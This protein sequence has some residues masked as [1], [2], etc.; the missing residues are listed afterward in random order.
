MQN[1]TT[2][3]AI[4]LLK[5]QYIKAHTT[6]RTTPSNPKIN[7]AQPHLWINGKVIY[8]WF[9]PTICEAAA[10][11]AYL[12]YLCMKLNWTTWADAANVNWTS[13]KYAIQSF[14][15]SNQWH[16]ILLVSNKLP[17]QA[18]KAHPHPGS[19]LC[20]SCQCLLEDHW[21]Y[22]EC[23]HPDHHWLF[24]ALKQQLTQLI[25]QYALHQSVFMTFWLSLLAI[26]TDTS[27]PISNTTSTKGLKGPQESRLGPALPGM[28][29]KQLG[30]Y[31]WHHAPY[32]VASGIQIM[33]KL[34]QLLW[35]YVLDTWKLSNQ[36]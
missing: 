31:H 18:S 16:I 34:T 25:L 26:R 8:Q 23:N 6:Q 13:L 9:L 12:D 11:A 29:V 7:A 2:S 5:Q 24:K 10:T 17:F 30:Y 1:N 36:H 35:K 20:P 19:H 22:F 4:S 28:H 3:N 33:T 14:Q 15:P 21:H 32:L 27:Y